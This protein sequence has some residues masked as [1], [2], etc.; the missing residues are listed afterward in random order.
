MTSNR[1]HG[2]GA[3][4]T[5]TRTPF[6]INPLAMRYEG[7]SPLYVFD[8]LCMGGGFLRLCARDRAHAVRRAIRVVKEK[9]LSVGRPVHAF[10]AACEVV[11]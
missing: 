6:P 10:A 5:D 11:S 1:A 7:A 2:S 9:N 4:M 3:V 8:V